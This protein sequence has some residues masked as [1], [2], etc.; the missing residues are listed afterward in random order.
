MTPK[1]YASG[2]TN[3]VF[4]LAII[5]FS[6]CQKNISDT[7]ATPVTDSLPQYSIAN[8][9]IRLSVVG[10][11]MDE[12]NNPV[13][14]AQITG[15]GLTAVTNANGIFKITNGNFNGSFATIKI[16]K[17]NYFTLVKT[18]SSTTGATQYINAKLSPKTLI[19]KIGSAGGNINFGNGNVSIS[20]PAGAFI[21]SAGNP[22]TD[23]VFVY[24]TYFDPAVADF[25]SRMPGNMSA[26]IAPS[27]MNYL[28][29]YG[30]VGI[31]LKDQN[32]QTVKLASGK[33]ATIAAN[34]PSSM[35]SAAPTT[36]PLWYFDEDKGVWVNQ[37]NASKEGS[38]YKGDVSHFTF[39]NYDING[40]L[41]FYYVYFKNRADGSPLPYYRFSI[42]PT[43]PVAAYELFDYTDGSG[44]TMGLLPANTDIRLRFFNVDGTVLLDSIIG[45]FTLPSNNGGTIFISL[46]QPPGIKGT[47]L[48]CNGQNITRGIIKA[49]IDSL[50]YSSTLEVN[51]NFYIPLSVLPASNT[52]IYITGYDSITNTAITPFTINY[53]DTNSL[54]TGFIFSCPNPPSQFIAYTI[55]GGQNHFFQ[56]N[57]DSAFCSKTFAYNRTNIACRRANGTPQVE[58]YVAFITGPNP[59]VAWND[60]SS[61]LTLQQYTTAST[62]SSLNIISFTESYF[63]YP[64]S[65][66]VPGW[67]IGKF[68]CIFRDDQNAVH[69]V[70]SN[71]KMLRN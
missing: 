43:T 51:G 29:S 44:A 18:F 7:I 1:N 33:K 35:L 28:T 17:N 67:V 45:P 61:I 16:E 22:I 39:W 58:G 6:S 31:E 46:P 21:N 70:R 5:L 15:G 36:I 41:T 59:P 13:Q 11:V 55:D 48:D 26:V 10:K 38:K 42:Q 65:L 27:A 69:T 52:P 71:F 23:S 56:R 49:N 54:K 68:T 30:M 20:F 37:G 57:L 47:L 64:P 4:F 32:A 25:N 14:G 66:A 2:F 12:M 62:P 34:I 63:S 50:D 8:T 60:T 3:I 53:T 19:G 9:P 24:G 40:P